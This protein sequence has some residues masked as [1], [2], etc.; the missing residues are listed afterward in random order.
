[1]LIDRK[2]KE[3]AILTLKMMP[4]DATY[5]RIIYQI[6]LLQAIHEGLEDMR[7]GRTYPDSDELFEEILGDE[8][9]GPRVARTGTSR[10]KGNTTADRQRSPKGSRGSGQANK[11][12]GA[13][14]KKV[15]GTRRTA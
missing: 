2:P 11:K 12:K 10:S 5:E 4:D 1:E 13:G 3:N 9:S 8:E 15:P 14:L 6:S 7:D